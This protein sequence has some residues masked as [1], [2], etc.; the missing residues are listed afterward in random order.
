MPKGYP[1]SSPKKKCEHC[2]DL[3][4][5]KP[6]M[7]KRGHARFCSVP[8][9]AKWQSETKKGQPKN[10]TPEWKAK[11]ASA[12][13]A[14]RG[15]PSGR[16]GATV[17]STLNEKNHNW[18]GDNVSYGS[19]HSWIRRKLGTPS[20]CWECGF[21]SNNSRQF[22]WANVSGEYRRDLEDFVRLCVVCHKAY[23]TGKIDL[24]LAQKVG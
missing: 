2:G 18:R 24:M 1:N 17:P 15:K 8:C 20:I 21:T 11:L 16:K 5:F 13:Y 22:H 3:F 19:L 23:D 4:R 14:R 7:Q 9:Q 10:W 6:A 12:N